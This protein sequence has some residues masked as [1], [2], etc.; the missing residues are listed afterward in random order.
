MKDEHGKLIGGAENQP[1]MRGNPQ[2]FPTNFPSMSELIATLSIYL[3]H[4]IFR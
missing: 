2:I 3:E 4:I 1:T